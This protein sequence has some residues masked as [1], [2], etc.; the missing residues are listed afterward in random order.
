M[1]S[2]VITAGMFGTEDEAFLKELFGD[3]FDAKEVE[4]HAFVVDVDLSGVRGMAYYQPEA[5]ADRIWNLTMIAVRPDQQGRGIGRALMTYVENALR[6]GGQ[7]L[8]VVETSATTQ[9]ARTREFYAQQGY[10]EEAQV[11]DYW[12]DGDV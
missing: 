3:Y 4:G 1:T 2:V 7:R 5:A 6:E 9:Y 12:S 11:R 10:D 8:L